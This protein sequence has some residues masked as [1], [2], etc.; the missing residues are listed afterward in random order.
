MTLYYQ[1]FLALVISAPRRLFSL[2]LPHSPSVLLPPPS[3]SLGTT[4][5]VAIQTAVVCKMPHLHWLR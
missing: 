3:L 1:I 4:N 5:V 2:P